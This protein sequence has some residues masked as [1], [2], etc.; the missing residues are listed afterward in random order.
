MDI[1]S[2]N[3]L[4]SRLRPKLLEASARWLAGAPRGCDT[5]DDVVQDTL[6]RLWAYRERLENYESVDAVAMITARR[7]AIDSIRKAGVLPSESFDS[8]TEPSSACLSPEAAADLSVS[9]AL[10]SELL[11]RLPDRQALVVKMRHSD[12]LELREIAEI[13]GMS[14]SNVRTLLSRGRT[15][16]RELY[17]S[18]ISSK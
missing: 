2:F 11:S 7:V 5:P 4:A 13:T 14:E 10:A 17:I 6:M 16:L 15:R 1:N 8:I 3:T 12:G 18:N 9:E